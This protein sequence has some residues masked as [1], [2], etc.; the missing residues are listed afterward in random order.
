MLPQ[1]PP[2]TTVHNYFFNL[3]KCVPVNGQQRP[4]VWTSSADALA[5]I[6]CG[7]GRHPSPGQCGLFSSTSRR[8]GFYPGGDAFFT[9]QL[10]QRKAAAVVSRGAGND[11]GMTPPV[12]NGAFMPAMSGRYR[13]TIHPCPASLVSASRNSDFPN[14]SSIS[15]ACAALRCTAPTSLASHSSTCPAILLSSSPPCCPRYSP[16]AVVAAAVLL[17]LKPAPSPPEKQPPHCRHPAP[18]TAPRTAVHRPSA[19]H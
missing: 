13:L 18:L 10:T 16:P 19:D 3:R 5:T 2:V 11:A 7:W 1:Q 12:T 4:R 9:V 17:M 14:T 6:Q 15:A 8:R